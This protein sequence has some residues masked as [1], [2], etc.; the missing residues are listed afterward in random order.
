M[1]KRKIFAGLALAVS[2]TLITPSGVPFAPVHSVVMAEAAELP[3]SGTL[4]CKNGETI[5]YTFENG[6]LTISGKGDQLSSKSPFQ[7]NQSITKV[8]FTDDCTLKNMESFFDYC[9]NLTVIENI[10]DT[11]TDMSRAFS[12]TGLTE[13]PKL[14]ANLEKL[15][16]TFSNCTGITEVDFSKMPS[17]AWDFSGAFKGTGVTNVTIAF[18]EQKNVK[19][20][21]NF[22]YAFS[23]CTQLKTMVV[24]ASNTDPNHE[25]WL[26]GLCDGCSELESFELKNIPENHKYPGAYSAGNMFTDCKNLVSVK[27]EGYFFFSG[28]EIFENCTS[29]KNVETKGFSKLFSDDAL[30]KAFMDCKAL[31]GTYYLQLYKNSK[32]HE[33][34]YENKDLENIKEKL[35]YA[36]KGCS[37]KVTFYINCKPLVDYCNTLKTQE[38]YKF[39]AT[40][41]YWEEA[42]EYK[43]P[44]ASAAPVTTETP[45]P[46]ETMIP[47]EVPS[48]G[49]PSVPV[50]TEAPSTGETSAPVVTQAPSTGETSVPV[51]TE[52]PSTGETSVPTATETPLPENP[53]TLPPAQIITPT[54]KP[55]P[56]KTATPKPT[57]TPT[58]VK[59]PKKITT[60]SLSKYKK[61]TKVITGK[62]ISN[63][64]VKV[65]VSN[66]NY[67]VKSNKKGAFTVKLKT[68]L[69]SKAAIKVTV[70]KSGY[71]TKTK[72]FKVK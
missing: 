44:E 51:G 72:S 16:Y 63:A 67:T 52:A 1:L 65:K 17:S 32:I 25:I 13:I 8:V 15:D 10:P 3:G 69:K 36:F 18:P 20:Y 50:V 12:G 9:R 48:T 40:L 30:D 71:T 2:V 47:T 26:Q 5:Q 45:L 56:E 64:K 66:K 53:S 70:S 31:E 4:P 61:G 33:G 38:E 39:D 46:V 59:K 22:A 24:D 23:D 29:L 6:V 54:Q 21:L 42:D 34:F 27:N 11:V 19:Y 62:T 60:L 7:R 28:S 41:V 37:D 68:K 14:P 35:K 43:R 49:E 57:K 55:V 58:P